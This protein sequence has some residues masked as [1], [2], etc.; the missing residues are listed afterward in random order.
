[1]RLAGAVADI[2]DRGAGGLR[3]DRRGLPG[4]AEIDGAGAKG[5][6]HRRAGG[7]FGPGHVIA[8]G[9][10]LF[11]EPAPALQQDQRGGGFLIA[12]LQGAVGG[13]G[14]EGAAEEGKRRGGGTGAKKGTALHGGSFG[15]GVG[16]DKTPSNYLVNR[17]I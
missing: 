2:D 3:E 16:P 6:E 5:F 12:D 9:S 4:E 13:G 1:M 14:G 17:V 11:L 15:V 10:E 7:E 8:Q